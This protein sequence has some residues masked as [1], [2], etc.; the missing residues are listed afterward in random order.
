M[1][2]KLACAATVLAC[3]VG[4]AM[5]EEIFGGITKVEEGKI[6]V[7]KFKKGEKP[8]KVTLDLADK[9]KVVNAKF[10]KEEMK[11]ETGEELKDG[12]KNDRF[13]NIGKFGVFARII[14]ND[15]GKVT[16]I[17][18][19]PPFKGKFKKKKKDD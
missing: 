17:Q 9:V 7:N 14:T 19:F 18:V 6:T 8:E 13:K 15:D 11:V 4:V 5:A 3:C 2:K 12:L 16:E 1:F 10:N